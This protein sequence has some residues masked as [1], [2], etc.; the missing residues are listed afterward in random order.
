[1]HAVDARDCHPRARDGDLDRILDRVGRNASKLDGFFDHVCKL[2][3]NVA[4]AAQ[5]TRARGRR[6]AVPCVVISARG[7]EKQG[8]WPYAR[9]ITSD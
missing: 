6:Y 2:S 8:D 9:K 7:L 4:A 5:L 1:M 3:W